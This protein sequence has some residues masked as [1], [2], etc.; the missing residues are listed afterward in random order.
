MK[1]VLLDALAFGD[2][3]LSVFEKLGEFKAYEQTLPEETITHVGDSDVII[4]NKVFIGKATMAA[5]PKL[6]LICIAATG[7]I[8]NNKNTHFWQS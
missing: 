1:I 2:S 7:M 5:N 8:E 4:T 6:K 3:D